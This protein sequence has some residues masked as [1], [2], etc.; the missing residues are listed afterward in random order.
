DIDAAVAQTACN[1]G[2]TFKSLDSEQF[3]TV[4]VKQRQ[5]TKFF[6][7]Q[8]EYIDACSRGDIDSGELLERSYVYDM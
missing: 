8:M 1:Y 4:A 7:F 3:L 5:L 6:V 2:S